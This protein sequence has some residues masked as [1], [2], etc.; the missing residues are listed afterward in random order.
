MSPD[1]ED[2]RRLQRAQRLALLFGS[3]ALAAL[4][5]LTLVLW[6]MGRDDVFV[7]PE[8]VDDAAREAAIASMVADATGVWDSHVDPDVGRVLQPQ[9]AGREYRGV[10]IHSNGYGMREA[11]FTWEKPAGTRRVILLGDSYVFGF[12]T[13]A[14][15]RMGVFLQ[16]FLAE[17]AA[18]QEGPLEV[19]HLAVSSW[20]IRA[21]SA[22][23]RR[24]V[25][26]L[27]PDLVVHVV[28]G[29]DL[30]DCAGVRGFGGMA[31]FSPQVRGRA[32][33]LVQLSHPRSAFGV[34]SGNHI[35]YG[36]DAESRGRY[37]DAARDLGALAR[38]VEDTGGRYLLL[39]RWTRYLPLVP[40]Q[41]AVEL[42]PEQVAYV[43][44]EFALEPRYWIEPG[45][46]H[47]NRAGHEQIARLIYGLARERGLLPELGLAAWPAAAEAVT[48]IHTAGA[49]T[50][51]R[52]ADFAQRVRR[53]R[54]GSRLDVADVPLHAAQ[55]VYAGWDG[56]G[57]LGPYASFMLAPEGGSQLRLSGAFLGRPELAGT[58]IEVFVEDRP[59]GELV[60]P[61]DDGGA[62]WTR[63]WALPAGVAT[64]R[65]V[66]VRLQADDYVYDHPTAQRCVVAHLS[67]AAIVP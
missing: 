23:L 19:L 31:R 5:A 30:D 61:A 13:A 57:R 54:I 39:A 66:N 52:T 67:S 27:A 51:A 65:A 10:T 12:G 20:N 37:R 47:W 11:P 41:L 42:R 14:E 9:L 58:R 59:V 4:A 62:S 49:R 8:S 26:R 1:H 15:D 2:R 56:E 32:D 34:S 63:T 50:A 40:Q 55:Q 36:I 28:C 25:S 38:S 18:D 64:S 24:Q 35:L 46:A 48:A 17:R 60:V 44:D 21:E 6:D 16:R 45:N 29:N 22:Y 33:G 53:L 3:V 7:A 43:G